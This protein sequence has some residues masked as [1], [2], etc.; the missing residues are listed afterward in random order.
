MV[1]KFRRYLGAFSRHN[2]QGLAYLMS[3][4]KRILMLLENGGFPEDTRVAQEAFALRDAGYQVRV[5][6]PT[7]SFASSKFE[8]VSGVATYRYPAPPEWGGFVGYVVE[9]VY[10]LTITAIISFYIFL[11]HG[12]D[13]LHVHTPPDMYVTIGF[14]YKIFGVKYVMDHHDLSPELYQAQS[15]GEGNSLV[16]RVLCWFERR[17]CRLADQLISTNQTQRSTAIQRCGVDPDKTNVVR[18]GPNILDEI[19][20]APIDALRPEGRTVVGYLGCIGYQ[21]GVDSFI[22]A[23]KVMVDKFER[24]DFHAVII[25]DGPAVPSLKAL[26]NELALDDHVVFPGYLK[27][28]TLQSHLVS[29]DIFVTPDPPSDYNVTCTMIKTMEYMALSR[30]IVGY[31]LPEH[32]FSA[33]D[34]SLY[35]TPDDEVD[36]AKCL[37]EL[38]D[39]PELQSSMGAIGRTRV[40]SELAWHHQKKSLVEAYRKLFGESPPSN[41]NST[42]SET[43]DH[44]TEPCS[45]SPAQ[46][47]PSD[48][49][50]H[51]HG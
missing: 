31:D 39:N 21:D 45:E 25:G 38:I 5:I 12:F 40:E 34:A 41:L 32:R 24:T 13:A 35:A 8:M 9:Y 6:S 17:S 36:F 11:R 18:N 16:Y 42:E 43:T 48:S 44:S 19:T 51:L 30:P 7:D 26:V 33:G 23:L 1:Y 46:P 28:E 27:G 2:S 29:C 10:S 15:D 47:I 37:L 14:F 4:G 22:R 50:H 20:A 49:P 3:R